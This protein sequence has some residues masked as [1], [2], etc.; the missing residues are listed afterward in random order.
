[1]L[2]VNYRELTWVI[3]FAEGHLRGIVRLSHHELGG[4]LKALSLLKRRHWGQV[5]LR[6]F[7]SRSLCEVIEVSVILL[8]SLK[9]ELVELSSTPEKQ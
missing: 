2:F 1:M 3:T 4:A 9:E 6:Y 5:L 7:A 8:K